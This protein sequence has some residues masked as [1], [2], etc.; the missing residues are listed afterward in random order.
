MEVR[1]EHAQPGQDVL[2]A[3]V[4]ERPRAVEDGSEPSMGRTD[5][6]S[7]QELEI[8]LD[9]VPN[10]LQGHEARPRH[11]QLDR[12]RRT[13]HGAADRHRGRKV[14][15]RQGEFQACLFRALYEQL[16]RVGIE[17]VAERCSRTRKGQPAKRQHVFFGEAQPH[18]RCHENPRMGADLDNLGHVRRCFLQVLEP[19]EDEEDPAV[20]QR[21]DHGVDGS[22]GRAHTSGEGLRQGFRHLSRAVECLEAGEHDAVGEGEIHE[23]VTRCSESKAGFPDASWSVDGEEPSVGRGQHAADLETLAVAPHERR[24]LRGEVVGR[25]G[26]QRWAGIS[27]DIGAARLHSDPEFLCGRH[28]RAGQRVPGQ[29]EQAMDTR[30]RS[31][32]QRRR[33]W[34]APCCF[35]VQGGPSEVPVGSESF[36]HDQVRF[37][38][39]PGE[40]FARGEDPF[41]EF[42]AEVEV[43]AVEEGAFVHV[44]GGFEQSRVEGLDQPHGV[45]GDSACQPVAVGDDDVFVHV[46]QLSV[47]RREGVSRV[48]GVGEEEVGQHASGL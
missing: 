34:Q 35:R 23:T 41:F 33:V 9:L 48:F 4:Q 45:A 3:L 7:V 36:P 14:V 13:S 16:E 5:P 8:A 39:P 44:D 37:S 47:G 26:N 15:L 10:R 32:V 29:L 17:R 43:E 24:G 11:R 31:R 46:A 38:Y 42:F 1:P 22:V 18:P 12:E 30:K 20:R 6:R 25:D 19:V 27:M 21:V 28:H 2:L 40:V